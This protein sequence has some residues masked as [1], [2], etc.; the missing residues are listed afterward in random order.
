MKKKIPSK[1]PVCV[2]A[3]LGL[4][5]PRHAMTQ[6]ETALT[7]M[8][9]SSWS[10]Q[11]EKFL[12]VLYHKT[13]I[14]KRGSVLFERP[15][16]S[17]RAEQN[18]FKPRKHDLDQGPGTQERMQ[19]FE[20]KAFELALPAC[21]TALRNAGLKGKDITHLVLVSCTGFS[22]PGLDL[23]LMRKLPLRNDIERV[24]VGFMGCH[25]AINGLRVAQALA[26][27]NP[28]NKVL[29]AAVEI[30]SIHYAYGKNA[31]SLVANSLFADGSAACVLTCRTAALNDWTVKSTGSF[32]FPGSQDAMSWKIGNHGF[33]MRLS[34]QVPKLIET[35]LKQ[36]VGKWLKKQGLALK[37]IKTWAIHPGGP[38]VLDSA[39]KGLCLPENS[40]GTSRLVLRDHGNMSSPTLLFII[41]RLKRARAPLP[42]VGLAFGPGLVTEAVL[43]V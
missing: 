2:L 30:A 13:R 31:D 35:G 19:V 1:K 39:E 41:E 37:D 40:L 36:Q 3:G 32:F 9:L 24:Q 17:P 5:V 28:E 16:G 15:K 29:L 10:E 27:Q 8:G 21:K 23:A 14:Q 4:S 20:K 22:S 12:Q 26:E 11:E 25:G 43:F 18:F 7:A 6:K 42:C 34:A 33:Q 38:K